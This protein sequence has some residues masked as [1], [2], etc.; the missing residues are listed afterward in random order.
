[1]GL[2]SHRQL[3]EQ[4]FV[5]AEVPYS[6]PWCGP[7]P[8]SCEVPWCFDHSVSQQPEAKIFVTGGETLPKTSWGLWQAASMLAGRWDPMGTF[9]P[10][11]LVPA[12]RWLGDQGRAGGLG[13]PIESLE[14]VHP[15]PSQNINLLMEVVPHLLPSMLRSQRPPPVPQLM[16][17]CCICIKNWIQIHLIG[18]QS[19]F[20][21]MGA[22]GNKQEDVSSSQFSQYMHHHQFCKLLPCP[23]L[24]FQNP[25]CWH[26][27][28]HA[29]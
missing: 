22:G 3:C 6:N 29:L 10:S 25:E 12:G 7:V 24:L 21:E 17:S 27:S 19:C 26:S 16:L 2:L 23:G 4:V 28:F 13:H 11:T 5:E 20:K 9:V 18:C 1:M 8:R 15:L 14:H